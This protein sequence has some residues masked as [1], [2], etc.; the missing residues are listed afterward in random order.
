VELKAGVGVVLQEAGSY[1]AFFNTTWDLD[2]FVHR[3][4][5]GGNVQLQWLF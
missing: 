5:D 4:W 2:I 1:R 3:Q